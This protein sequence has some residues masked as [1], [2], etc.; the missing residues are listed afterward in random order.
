MLEGAWVILQAKDQPG[1]LER[2]GAKRPDCRPAED[3]SDLVPPP[4]IVRGQRRGPCD[5]I[6]QTDLVLDSVAAEDI[7]YGK[8]QVP[9][10]QL[11]P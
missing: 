2:D 5:V 4:Q 9:G 7:L 3:M 6:V 10:A 1:R 8:C 11:V